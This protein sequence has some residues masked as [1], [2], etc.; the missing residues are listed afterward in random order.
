MQANP[1]QFKFICLVILPAAQLY[2]P[3]GIFRTL[4]NGLGQKG[5]AGAGLLGGG[6]AFLYHTSQTVVRIRNNLFQG[7]Q[8]L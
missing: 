5:H 7:I 2:Q 8:N 6:C 3:S 1:L 4:I